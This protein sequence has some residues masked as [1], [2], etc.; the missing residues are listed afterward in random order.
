MGTGRSL[1]SS[2]R[3][4]HK[5]L[6]TDSLLTDRSILDEIRNNALLLIKRDTNLRRLWS[7]DTIFTT[8]PCLEMEEVPI[9]ECANYTDPC[10]IARSK[11]KIP[12]IAEGNYQYIIQ[13]VY[14]INIMGGTGKKIKEIS[15]NRYINL[16]KLP[17]IRKEEYFWISNDYLYVTNPLIQA[18]RLVALFE[19]DV[20]NDILYTD[21]ACANPNIPVEEFCKNP[22]DKEFPLPG[23]L[24]KQVL[25]LTSQ[26]LLATYFNL[27]TDLAQDG[28]DNQSPNSITK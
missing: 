9:S 8:L 22:L 20:P 12:R 27:R 3:S 10:S 17:I 6:S 13:G 11:F 24:K 2:C 7:T 21:C 4:L 25:D 1:V 16:L 18:V 23:Y 28:I 26:K 5:L 14:S 19:K 15:I